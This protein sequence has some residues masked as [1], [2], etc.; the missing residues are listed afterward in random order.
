M[1]QVFSHCG[2]AFVRGQLWK[3]ETWPDADDIR[4]P[5]RT[6]AGAAEEARR[7]ESDVRREVEASY[8]PGVL[9]GEPAA[10]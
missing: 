4:S 1:R 9:Y 5:S 2:K 3:P 8:Q 7:R 6:I 10:D